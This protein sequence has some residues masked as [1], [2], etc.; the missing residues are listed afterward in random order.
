M[1]RNFRRNS[2]SGEERESDVSITA[3]RIVDETSEMARA[4]AAPAGWHDTKE[5]GMER[6][7]RSLRVSVHT[8]DRL[9]RG[10]NKRIDAHLYLTIKQKYQA[11]ERRQFSE[12]A[13]NEEAARLTLDQIE[14]A[15]NAV[16]ESTATEVDEKAFAAARPEGK[17]PSGT[18]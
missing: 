14:R 8:V 11:W 2:P 17:G 1:R 7:A 3:D 13:L 18:R 5:R 10:R 12:A 4:L 16:S 15:D 6:L 9:I